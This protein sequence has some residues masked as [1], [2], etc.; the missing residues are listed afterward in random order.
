[1]PVTEVRALSSDRL[2]LWAIFLLSALGYG[3][4][5]IWFPLRPNVGRAPPGDIRTFAPTLFGGLLY[6]LLL[7]GLFGLLVAAFRRAERGKL[8]ARPLPVILAGSLVLALPL[9]WAYPVNATDVF[10]YVI[11][12]RVAGIYGES[13]YVTPPADLIGDPFMPLAGEWAGETSPYGP[14][15]ETVAAGLA[16]VAGDNLFAAVVLFKGLALL[17]F[18]ATAALIGSLLPHGPS[19]PAYTLLWAWN[20]ALLL[21]FVLNG[22][23]DALMLLWLALGY[24]L[25]R[26]DRPVIGFL[27]M[28]LAA[29]TKPVAALA[30]PFFFLSILRDMPRAREWLRLTAAALFGAAFLAWLAF[31]PWAGPGGYLRTPVEL[32]LRLVREATSSAGF[33]PAVWIYMALGQGIPIEVIGSAT[34]ALFVAFL[35]WLLWLAWRGRSPLR[36]AADSF[37]GWTA[38]ALSFRVWY[39]VWPFPW[40]LLDAGG[41]AGG[42]DGIQEHCAA[43]RLRVGLWFLLTSQLSVIVYGHLRVFALGGDQTAAHLIGV[44]FVFA[45]PW[46]LALLPARLSRG[47]HAA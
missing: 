17:C 5:V 12:G 26:H 44:P 35:L 34:R 36:G 22:H 2:P 4:L 6:A 14:L 39:A 47:V 11:R 8:G 15:W 21:T 29:L 13:P 7:I 27:V 32:A 18:L 38:A 16:A 46:L 31:L 37:L 25:W 40:L 1:M 45:L 23:N 30:L 33:S 43:Y 9:L 10:R 19:R 28:T 3:I 20:P 41:E 42:V 24:W